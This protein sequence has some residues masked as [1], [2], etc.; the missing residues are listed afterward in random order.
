MLTASIAMLSL[1][2]VTG[3]LMK[4]TG[5]PDIRDV[6]AIGPYYA[7]RYHNGFHGIGGPSGVRAAKRAKTKRKGIARAKANG[8]YRSAS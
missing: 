5:L 6:A 4:A 3:G 1:T 8:C 7:Y 2:P